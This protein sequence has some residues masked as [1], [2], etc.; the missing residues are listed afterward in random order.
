M[1]PCAENDFLN[2]SFPGLNQEHIDPKEKCIDLM[3]F[4]NKMAEEDAIRER[5]Y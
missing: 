3:Q 4:F 2:S 5:E 1:Q